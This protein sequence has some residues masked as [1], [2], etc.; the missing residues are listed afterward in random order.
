MS[1]SF[2][3]CTFAGYL[4]KDP[5]LTSKNDNSLVKFA[6]AVNGYKEGDVY[7]QDCVAWGKQAESIGTY[8]R[9]GSAILVTGEMKE[10]KWTHEGKEYRRHVLTVLRCQFLDKK[11]TS[12][13]KSADDL[14]F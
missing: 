10:D 8:I 7:F 4:T 6:I 5:D 12:G 1:I 14:P 11:A 9:T 13:E 2:N 3:Q